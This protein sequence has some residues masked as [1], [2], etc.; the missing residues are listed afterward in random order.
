MSTELDL[1][2]QL[3]IYG[4][5]REAGLDLSTPLDLLDLLYSDEYSASD[6]SAYVDLLFHDTRTLA[7]GGSE[8]LDL[9]GSLADGLGNTL[10]FAYVK[11]LAIR[12]RTAGQ[13]LTVGNAAA[14]VFAGPFGADAHT[15]DIPYGGPVVLINNPDGFAVTAGTDD[16]LKIANSAG[17][18]C[19][20]DIIIAGSTM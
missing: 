11:F 1:K 3:S 13:T 19:E 4:N 17:N 16:K 12:V 10:T 7:G 2:T 20:Y 9:A 5:Y 6:S 14:N 15:I 8:E 18:P